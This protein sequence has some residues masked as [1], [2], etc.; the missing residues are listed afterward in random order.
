MADAGFVYIPHQ[1][2]TVAENMTFL[3][4]FCEE[5]GAV[6]LGPPQGTPELFYQIAGKHFAFSYSTKLEIVSFLSEDGL[7]ALVPTQGRVGLRSLLMNV[8]ALVGKLVYI[9]QSTHF[10][11]TLLSVFYFSRNAA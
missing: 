11:M 4:D 6:F 8:K 2:N 1:M 9:H 10:E 7:I 3:H 5:N